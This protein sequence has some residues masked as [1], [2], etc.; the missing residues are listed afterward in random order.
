MKCAAL[1][2]LC[3]AL[4][5]T[6]KCLAGSAPL[7][8][9]P[10]P[11]MPQPNKPNKPNKPLK[12]KPLQDHWWF[13]AGPMLCFEAQEP[14]TKRLMLGGIIAPGV[15]CHAITEFIRETE[16][17]RQG[18]AYDVDDLFYKALEQYA[19]KERVR[20]TIY[21]DEL[22]VTDPCKFREIKYH[23]LR[24]YK[25]AGKVPPKKAARLVK[26]HCRLLMKPKSD[27][28]AQFN[29]CLKYLQEIVKENPCNSFTVEYRERITNSTPHDVL[30]QNE[31]LRKEVTK[32]LCRSQLRRIR[33]RREREKATQRFMR[34]L[35]EFL[36]GFQA[37]RV[38]FFG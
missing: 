38:S 2:L 4:E 26:K 30:F 11:K 17:A 24:K 33:N 16:K 10:V 31:F 18:D 20:S 22:M 32:R 23:K 12:N 34:K 29:E 3:L 19:S 7:I 1:L 8:N 35:G 21:A 36:G 25:I 28:K 5:Y 9:V 37:S 14:Q 6:G 27:K 13:P 15:P